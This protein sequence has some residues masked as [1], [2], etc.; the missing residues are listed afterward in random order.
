MTTAGREDP[1]IFCRGVRLLEICLMIMLKMSFHAESLCRH[2]GGPGSPGC[3]D[4]P[5]DATQLTEN[6]RSGDHAGLVSRYEARHWPL[7]GVALRFCYV[8]PRPT[9]ESITSPRLNDWT[10]AWMDLDR[11]LSSERDSFAAL[12]T[13]T[14][15]RADAS[16]EAR[17]TW[18]TLV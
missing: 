4:P 9:C 13:A 5:P 8:A 6:G 3:P 7:R 2:P 11:G 14:R 15:I 12:P 16:G 10:L 1:W 17:S 18:T